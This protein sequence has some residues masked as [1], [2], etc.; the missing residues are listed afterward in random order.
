MSI[1]P[2]IF[3]VSQLGVGIDPGHRSMGTKASILL[4][5]STCHSSPDASSTVSSRKTESRVR[6]PIPSDFIENGILREH[7]EVRSSDSLSYPGSIHLD[8]VRGY[9][10]PFGV[11]TYLVRGNSPDLEIIRTHENLIKTFTH[12]T[13]IPIIKVSRLIRCRTS[14][15]L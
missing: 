3:Q 14:S 13:H 11:I 1:K 10:T 12:I 9:H 7:L 8:M 4:C 2:T 15:R 5:Y 6:A